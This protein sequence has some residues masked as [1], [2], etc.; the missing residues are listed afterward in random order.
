MSQT[1]PEDRSAVHLTLLLQAALLLEDQAAAAELIAQLRPLAGLPLVAGV[2]SSSVGRHLGEAAALLGE[3]ASARSFYETA[4][5]ATGRI[6]HRP[7]QA[8]IHLHA[9]L[10]LDEA[11]VEGPASKDRE[12]ALGTWT[13]PSR[14]SAP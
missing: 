3:G 14:S 6:R 11:N 5:E 2:A 10:L 12:E 7:E 1:A 4:L 13:S 8:L 9:E